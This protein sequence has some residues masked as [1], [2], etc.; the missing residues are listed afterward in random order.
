MDF[1]E[2]KTNTKIKV[3]GG[4]ISLGYKSE[5]FINK[6][7]TIRITL[8]FMVLILIFLLMFKFSKLVIT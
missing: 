3:F 7:N 8:N 6:L 4:S 2:N 5:Y 1:F